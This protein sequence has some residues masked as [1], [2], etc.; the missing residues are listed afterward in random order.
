MF[1]PLHF[2]IMA[3]DLEIISHLIKVGVNVNGVDIA[4]NSPMHLA[5]RSENVNIVKILLKAEAKVNVRNL[6]KE[7]PV[8][9]AVQSEKDDVNILKLLV[10]AGA[11]VKTKDANKNSPLHLALFESNEKIIKFL[12][13][14]GANPNARD[15]GRFTALHYACQYADKY[16]NIIKMLLKAGANVNAVNN[17]GDIAASSTVVY[18][19]LDAFKYLLKAGSNINHVSKFGSTCVSLMIKSLGISTNYENE[20]KLEELQETIKL[21]IEYTDVNLTDANGSNILC[22]VLEGVRLAPIKNLYYRIIVDHVTKLKALNYKVDPSLLQTIYRSK[23][24]RDCFDECTQE[25]EKAKNTRPSSCYVSFFNLLT[26]HEIKFV[27]YAGN[28]DLL[29]DFFNRVEEFQIYGQEMLKNVY[30]GMEGRKLVDR[31]SFILSECCPVFDPTHLVI[32]DLL[33]TLS[34]GDWEELC[35]CKIDYSIKLTRKV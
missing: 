13:E 32:K 33:E 17:N 34:E 9:I 2:A 25:L 14:N 30:K 5:V 20:K 18:G 6:A 28:E 16:M 35:G 23:E 26:D 11:S 10:N 22:N 19:H 3:E 4:G 29:L 8:H 27:R 1:S 15:E 24:Y 7:T 12:L 31:A 21:A